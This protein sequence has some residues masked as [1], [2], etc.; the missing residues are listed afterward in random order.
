MLNLA[1]QDILKSII[2]EDIFI[3]DLEA[4]AIKDIEEEEEDL[5]IEDN[6]I[7]K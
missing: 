2:K 6:T 1:V 4:K 3:E 5:I 7:G